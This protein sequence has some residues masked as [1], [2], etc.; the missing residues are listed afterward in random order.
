MTAVGLGQQGSQAVGS[1][2]ESLPCQNF[3][4]LS[5]TF[6]IPETS[7]TLRGSYENFRH[8]ETKSFRPK[9]VNPPFSYPQ[10][11]SILE[12]NEALKDSPTKLFGT[13]RLKNFD[14]KSLYSPPPLLSINFFATGNCLKHRSEGFLYEIF[15]H[16][17]TKKNSTQ[18]REITLRGIKSFDTRN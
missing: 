12:T 4:D 16:C 1:G 11:F 10:G 8:C 3:Y 5:L 9:I 17:E 6:S 15:R 7:E 2:F 13:V 18:N 14:G